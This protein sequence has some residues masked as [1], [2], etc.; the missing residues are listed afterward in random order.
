VHAGESMELTAIVAGL[1]LAAGGVVVLI[2]LVVRAWVAGHPGLPGAATELAGR[3]AGHDRGYRLRGLGPGE[4][5]LVL[6][7]IVGLAAVA[8]AAVGVGTLVDD[9]TD[10]DGVA[11]IDHPVAR[12]VTAHRTGGLTA[13]MKA[14]SVVGGPAGMTVL[15]LATGLLL[16]VVWRWWA[17][18]VVLAVTAAGVIGLTVVFKE[19]LGRARPP[20]AQAVAAADGYGFPSGHAAAAAAVCAAAAWLCSLRS[21]SWRGRIAAWAAAAML[22]ALVGISRVYLGVHWT[23]DVIGGWI[24]GILWMAVVVTGWATFGHLTR[25]RR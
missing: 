6:T 1:L 8:L 16:G 5:L 21:R 15:A 11:V 25:A 19:A 24:F 4:N 23:S 13:V 7:L 2:G 20:L 22:A 9:V 10:G 3:L 17:P 14:A 18:G 12:F